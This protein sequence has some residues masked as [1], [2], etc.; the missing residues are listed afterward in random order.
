MKVTRRDS[1]VLFYDEEMVWCCSRY[2]QKQ[3]TKTLLFAKTWLRGINTS[4]LV[5]EMQ[6]LNLSFVD[7]YN[8]SSPDLWKH[9]LLCNFTQYIVIL[10]YSSYMKRK[11][12]LYFF[13][14]NKKMLCYVIVSLIRSK[15][16]LNSNFFFTISHKTIKQCLL[17]N[18]SYVRN[19][20]CVSK[21]F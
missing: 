7:Y 1:G 15:V 2:W 12:Q 3:L 21:H 17:N 14:R 13:D 10:S 18:A 19:Q 20:I 11:V 16:K 6:Y 5:A 8:K 9:K 4:Q